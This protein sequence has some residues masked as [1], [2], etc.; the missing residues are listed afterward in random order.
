M[1]LSIILLALTL[2]GGVTQQ[3]YAENVAAT[4]AGLD[5]ADEARCADQWASKGTNQ[6]A[7]CMWVVELPTTSRETL[8]G[9]MRFLASASLI[10]VLA[11]KRLEV[12]FG[13]GQVASL[14]R[15][16]QAQ[17]TTFTGT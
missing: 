8:S 2:A 14:A 11:G 12:S 17:V 6:F 16:A 3:Q 9:P 15:P 4:R 5:A 1:R 10:Q 13:Q 7:E